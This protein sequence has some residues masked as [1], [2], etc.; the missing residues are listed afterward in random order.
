M[1]QDRFTQQ[2]P[3]ELVLPIYSPI[4]PIQIPAQLS[5]TIPSDKSRRT[6][7]EPRRARSSF[8]NGLASVMRLTPDLKDAGSF[9]YH[10]RGHKSGNV[11]SISPDGST[12]GNAISPGEFE[13]GCERQSVVD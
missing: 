11:E 6:A 1:S 8:A 12:L 4:R 3:G 7:V 10:A 9:D 13:G 2:A 5:R